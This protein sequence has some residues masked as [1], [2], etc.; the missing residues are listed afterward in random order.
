MGQ[1]SFDPGKDDQLRRNASL[2][3]EGYLAHVARFARVL[4]AI[5]RDHNGCRGWLAGRI[6]YDGYRCDHRA[7]AGSHGKAFVIFIDYF[8]IGVKRPGALAGSI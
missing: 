1:I 2:K 7:R 4:A 3:I 6:G 5:A 8:L